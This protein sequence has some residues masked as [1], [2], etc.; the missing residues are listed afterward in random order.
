MRSLP[1]TAKLCNGGGV[2][3]GARPPYSPLGLQRA[4]AKKPQG[5]VPVGNTGLN[6][7]GTHREGDT[8]VGIIYTKKVP[9]TS[10]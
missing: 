3:R 10:S 5:N 6:G 1:A 8:D 9:E 2:P 4:A 7:K